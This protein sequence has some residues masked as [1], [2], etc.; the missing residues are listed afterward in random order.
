MALMLTLH[1]TLR[2]T[3]CHSFGQVYL[4][5]AIGLERKSHLEKKEAAVV[6]EEKGGGKTV[7]LFRYRR[8]IDEYSM[9]S[10]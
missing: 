7:E 6:E 8:R 3:T 9:S 10:S 1:G 2:D 5:A 4:S